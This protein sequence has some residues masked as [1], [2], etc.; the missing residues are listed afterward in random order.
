[1]TLKNADAYIAAVKSALVKAPLRRAELLDTFEQHGFARA[2]PPV[3]VITRWGTWLEAGS[4]HYSH[5]EAEFAWIDGTETDSTAVKKLQELSKMEEVKQ[6]LQKISEICPVITSTIKALQ[7][8]SLPSSDVWL[9]LHTVQGALEEAFESPPGKLKLYT[10]SKHPALEFWNNVQ[11][12]DPRKASL[13]VEENS[14][15]I[16]GSISCMLST[17]IPQLELIKYKEIRRTASFDKNFCPF[18]FWQS[19]SREMPLLSSAALMALS[20]PSS[21]AEVERSFSS[22]KRILTPLRSSL[23]EENLAVHLQL[24]FNKG[25]ITENVDDCE[26]VDEEDC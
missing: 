5:L 10:T 9:L 21:S 2:L 25:V 12:L 19:F 15:S 14:E 8:N 26:L 24:A 20:I 3:P 11:Y 18:K 13:F 23:T 4:F 16:P 1:M 6:E 7:Q 22:L 17:E